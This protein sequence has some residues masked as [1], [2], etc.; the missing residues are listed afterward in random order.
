MAGCVRHGWPRRASRDSL[1]AVPIERIAVLRLD[2]DMY[3]ST[4]DGLNHL[5]DKLSPGGIVIIDDNVLGYC[6]QAVHD[7]RKLEGITESI[8]WIDRTGAIWEKA[9]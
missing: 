2:G 1:P 8:Q 7:Y 6:R 4:M 9:A 5:Y 3:E